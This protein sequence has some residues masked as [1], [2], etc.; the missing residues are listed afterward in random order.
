MSTNVGR[1]TVIFQLQQ[2]SL[3]HFAIMTF[4]KGLHGIGTKLMDTEES[5][6]HNRSCP[7]YLSVHSITHTN[8]HSSKTK[9]GAANHNGPTFVALNYK[10]MRKKTGLQIREHCDFQSA[11]LGSRERV[12]ANM[13]TK[14]GGSPEPWLVVIRMAAKHFYAQRQRPSSQ[15]N[16]HLQWKP[17]PSQYN[18][19]RLPIPVNTVDGQRITRDK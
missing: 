18:T 9:N 13:I 8:G 14:V 2:N 4:L 17:C 11:Y 7:E 5:F 1:T 3:K 15:P 19:E 12:W 6:V 16:R 10:S